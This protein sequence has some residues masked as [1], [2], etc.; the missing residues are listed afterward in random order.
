MCCA[1]F[2]E[3]H[4]ASL[5]QLMLHTLPVY[6]DSASQRAVLATVKQAVT[7]GTFL[8]TLAGAIVKLDAETVSRQVNKMLC[9]PRSTAGVLCQP[10]MSSTPDIVCMQECFVLLCWTA[11]VLRQLQ[12]SSAKKA[13]I[14]LV[15]CQVQFEHK[16]SCLQVVFS[17]NSQYV[18]G[19]AV[20]MQAAYLSRLQ[21]MPATAENMLKVTDRLLSAKPELL[22]EYVVVAKSKGTDATMSVKLRGSLNARAAKPSDNQLIACHMVADSPGLMYALLHFGSQ[23]P[24]QLA[25]FRQ[26]LLAFFF[27]SAL[28]AKLPV[29]AE[30]LDAYSPLASQ[31]SQVEFSSTVLPAI[32]KYVRRT[33]DAALVSIKAL[34]SAT[35]LD[36]S[37][38]AHDLMDQLLKLV[39]GS[40]ESVRCVL[41]L[42]H[43]NKPHHS[44]EL[45]CLVMNSDL[46]LSGC[47]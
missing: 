46:T 1:D 28:G 32:L 12:V 42:L 37:S 10:L 35:Q 34:L 15:E 16:V 7:N 6:Q 24:K 36:L 3:V 47:S 41:F 45:K 14:K 11:V 17:T 44:L 30:K 4:A 20:L 29:S 19:F 31:L 5:V 2:L 13:V 40:K 39:R 23:H 22:P 25:P 8:K 21:P 18:C 9:S 27:E 26:E 43:Q 33:P 38:S